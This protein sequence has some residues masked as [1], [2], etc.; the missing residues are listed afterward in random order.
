MGTVRRH[1]V[2][3]T[4]PECR[5]KGNSGHRVDTFASNIS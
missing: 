4:R 3:W 5:A 2:G 1:G